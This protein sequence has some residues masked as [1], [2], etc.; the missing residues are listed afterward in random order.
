MRCRTAR[1]GTRPIRVFL[2]GGVP[3]V[4]LHLRERG[5][6]DL[7]CSD[8]DRRDRSARTSTGGRRA[9]AG[10]GSAICSPRRTAWTRTT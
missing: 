6:L 7:N 5:L 8:G 10:S 3:E 1:S 9:T 4:M 2:A